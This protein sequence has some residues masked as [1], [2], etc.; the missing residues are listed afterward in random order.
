MLKKSRQLTFYL[1]IDRVVYCNRTDIPSSEGN[2]NLKVNIGSTRY[3]RNEKYW[4][5]LVFRA[6]IVDSPFLK[7]IRC[8]TSTKYHLFSLSISIS[9][10][11]LRTLSA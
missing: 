6:A 10:L 2:L 4:I 5:F 8:G 7:T 9:D 1:P 3:G 11:N